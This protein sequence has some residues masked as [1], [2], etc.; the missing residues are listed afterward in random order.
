MQRSTSNIDTATYI[1]ILQKLSAHLNSDTLAALWMTTSNPNL[2]Y[3]T[4]KQM[5]ENGQ[6]MKL[7]LF[8]DTMLDENELDK[9]RVL[10]KRIMEKYSGVLKR[11]A[12]K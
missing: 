9:Q 7:E 4:P 12:D 11:L 10:S 3:V 6:A 2:G 1:R 5:I 8:I